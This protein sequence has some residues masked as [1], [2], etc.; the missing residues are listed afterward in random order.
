MRNNKRP[1]SSRKHEISMTCR[2]LF[3]RLSEYVDGELSQEICEEIR[4]HMDGCEPCVAFANTLKKTA[5][6]C[7]R[8]PSKPIPAEVAADLRAL[9]SFHLPKSK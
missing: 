7:R 1:E 2:D 9:I 5:E 3:E 6:L 4:R 8:L